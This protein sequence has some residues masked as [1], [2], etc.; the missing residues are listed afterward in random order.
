MTI[1]HFTA[2]PLPPLAPSLPCGGFTV[3]AIA[4]RPKIS[5]QPDRVDLYTCIQA[6][7]SV[8]QLLEERPMKCVLKGLAVVGL[9][10]T[11]T[12]GRI[13]VPSRSRS[14]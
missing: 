3:A 1:Y 7:Q 9:A 4:R 14:R 2:T 11:A 13:A 8:D 10:G 5:L 12:T 6:P